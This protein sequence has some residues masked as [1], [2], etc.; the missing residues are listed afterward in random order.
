M[1]PSLNLLLLT[2]FHKRTPLTFN[3]CIGITATAFT[4]WIILQALT[5]ALFHRDTD[6]KLETKVIIVLVFYINNY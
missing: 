1:A 6:K 3:I 4:G 5:P 2:S